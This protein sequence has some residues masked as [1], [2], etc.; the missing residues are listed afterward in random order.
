ME[1]R[2]SINLKNKIYLV[3]CREK[4]VYQNT[5]RFKYVKL[6][7]LGTLCRSKHADSGKCW[8]LLN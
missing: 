4:N 2:P 3:I 5:H 8:G 6:F 7:K 1:Y